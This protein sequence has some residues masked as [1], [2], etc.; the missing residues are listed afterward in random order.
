[1]GSKTAVLAPIMSALVKTEDK[2]GPDRVWRAVNAAQQRFLRE[3]FSKRDELC[4]FS[5]K[6][7]R[8]W[9]SDN[10]DELNTLLTKEGFSIK[11]FP[12]NQNEY[13]VVSILDVLVEWVKEAR[14]KE[15][16]YNGKYYP[17]VS[18]KPSTRTDSGYLSVFTAY[19]IPDNPNPI[20]CVHTKSGDK[21]YITIAPDN[22][23]EI[24]LIEGIDLIRIRR[25]SELDQV[26]YYDFLEFPMIDYDQETDI[27]WLIGLQTT[28]Q[29][30]GD[31]FIAQAKQQTKFKMNQLGAR[32][33]S[34]VAIETRYG[35]SLT[36]PPPSILRIDKPFYLW[37]ERKGSTIPIMYG[38]FD[39][40]DWKDPKSLDM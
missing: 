29:N 21:V 30:G 35:C 1:M 13:G 34:A 19:E 2:L 8:S 40:N 31:W 27:S 15:I 4:N 5:P 6:E 38:Y 7:L 9:I 14:K 33:K 28:D 12:L 24:D 39:V 23:G 26:Y 20:A 11:L 18:M 36:P 16:F 3:Y 10:A 37:T 22:A 17:G 32:V 25:R